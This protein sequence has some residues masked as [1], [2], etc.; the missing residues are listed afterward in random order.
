MKFNLQLEIEVAGVLTKVC[1]FIINR[2]LDVPI[3]K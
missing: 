1:E 2:N 3:E